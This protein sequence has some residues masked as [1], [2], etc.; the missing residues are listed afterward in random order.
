MRSA[1]L[2]FH[3]RC[4]TF[5]VMLSMI[6]S[7]TSRLKSQD[8][9]LRRS[10]RP[11]IGFP[12]SG[13][14]QER[15][16]PEFKCG[17]GPITEGCRRRIG[18]SAACSRLRGFSPSTLLS[19]SVSLCLVDIVRSQCLSSWSEHCHSAVSELASIS[20]L[21][22]CS[23]KTMSTATQTVIVPVSVDASDVDEHGE[24]VVL[25]LMND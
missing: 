20:L 12:L 10:S 2:A 23:N 11:D 14:L 25:A 24:M 5:S 8:G 21:I 17:N 22:G 1:H 9:G 3:L 18:M 4:T 7:M 6:S 15:S 13:N 16:T 19:L